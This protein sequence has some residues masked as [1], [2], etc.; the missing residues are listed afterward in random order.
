MSAATVLAGGRVITP[1]RAVEGDVL[2]AG[3]R[4]QDIRPWGPPRAGEERVDCAGCWVGPGLVDIH[5]HGGGGHDFAG[6]D[7]DAVVAGADYHLSQGTT[8]LAPSALS[9]PFDQL[10]RAIRAARRAAGRSRA[11]ILGFH[12]EGVYLDMEYRGGHLARH[13]HDPDPREY[14]PLLEAH[15]DFITE[16]TLAPEL[17]GA[18]DVIAACR[19]AGIMPS[20]GHTRASYEQF[21]AAI[22][23]GLRH[24][25]HYAC[26][27]GN[28]RFEVLQPDKT[29][30]KGFA[31]GVLEAVLLHDEVTTELICDGFHLHPAFVQLVVKC[32]GPRGV[33]LVSDTV[34]GVG[35]PEGE[36]TVG[37]QPTLMKNGIAIIRDRPEIIASSVTPLSGMVRWAH[38]KAGL[39]LAAAWEMASATPARVIGAD[40]RKGILAPRM[41]ADVLVMDQDLNIRGVYVAGRRVQ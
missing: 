16:W 30:G 41:D 12:V 2:L 17:P 7:P 3:G 29:T 32:K 24:T 26:C 9:I 34:F 21:L 33:C 14:R 20:A 4:V 6:D 31:P 8:S 28:M 36:I 37:D 23:A 35:L 22:E 27:M 5:V 25:T 40:D 10:D 18:L 1:F 38:R 13:V 15:A 11:T 19:E 39:P